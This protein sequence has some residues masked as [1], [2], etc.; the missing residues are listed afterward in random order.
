MIQKEKVQNKI[1]IK[2]FGC[3]MNNYDSDR[4]LESVEKTH[5]QV[6][7]P[8]EAD[9]IVF[10]TCHIREKAS[11]KIYSEVGKI[12]ELKK[13]NK[14]LKLIIVGC[15]AQAEGKAMIKRQP[16]IDAVIGPQMYH[17]FNHVLQNSKEK[18]IL[19]LNFDTNKKFAYLNKKRTNFNTSSFVTVQEGCNKFCSFCV[20]PFTRGVE[21]SRNAE[22]ILNEIRCLV[23]KGTKEVILLG[24]NV[25]AYH[26]LDQF[27][28]ETN[29]AKLIINL[30]KI[31][32]LERLSYTT[33]HPRDMDQDLI[34]LH[35]DNS[36]LNPYLHLPV[37]SG[38]N[39][40]LNL[41]NRKYSKEEYLKIVEKLRKKRPDIALSSDFIIG[42]PGETEKDFKQTL[43]LVKEVNFSQAYS[44]KYTS[45][46]GTKSSRQKSDEVSKEEKDQR[47]MEIQEL[48]NSQQKKFNSKFVSKSLRVLVKGKGNKLNQYRGTT[49][50]MQVVNF[51]SNKEI[52]KF[53]K[54]Q[55]T[56]ASNNSLLGE[57]L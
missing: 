39:R 32:G 24:Q 35:G 42:Y 43:Q 25:N 37:Q 46:P 38:S 10:N 18:P 4:L 48:L 3:Q 51:H 34:D 5:K 21:S 12:K 30:E 36:I 17:K 13:A 50:W 22:D 49:K 19:E 33:S 55:I 14:N 26:G 29:L 40:I 52:N 44:F 2:T 11:E 20:V 15:V 9:T 27:G 6:S 41:M 57:I 53:E 47:L 23:E 56:K 28:I 45:R 16:I 54:V 31:K 8:N 1:Y 7:S